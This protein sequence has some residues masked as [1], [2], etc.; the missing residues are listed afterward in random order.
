MGAGYISMDQAMTGHFLWH[1]LALLA[2]LKILATVF[3]VSSG[4]PGGMFAPTLFVGGMLGAAVGT[5]Q[6]RFFPAYTGPV[7][8]YALVGMGTLFAGFLRV[9]MTS[10]F[11]VLE[12]S[13][14]YSMILPVLVSNTIAYSVSRRF[15]NLPIF[16]VMTAQD[17][18]NLPSMEEHRE[19][20]V[21]RVEDAMRPPPAVTF[22]AEE[23]VQ[24][25]LARAPEAG[26]G[27]LFVST[28]TGR[29]T[30]VK[31]AE[32]EEAVRDGKQ[33]ELVGTAAPGVRVPRL[34]GDQPL[35]VALRFLHGSESLPV[36]HRAQP[37]VVVGVLSLENLLSAYRRSSVGNVDGT[38]PI[39]AQT[40]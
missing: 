18:L 38:G 31:R 11:M 26:H 40:P 10:V 29:W 27:A 22:R 16:D 9:P 17:G 30:V 14:N 19:T 28:S 24:S 34:H 33:M 37:R 5:L 21:L 25:V 2:L 36:V 1:I 4:A 13:G 6:A 20:R 32:L 7:G 12:T 35:E 39:A 8:A 15:Q 23:T 3:S